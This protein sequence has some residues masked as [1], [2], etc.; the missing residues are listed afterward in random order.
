[1]P[2]GP[3][4]ASRPASGAIRAVSPC[5]DV[6][7]FH[8]SASLASVLT[9][10]SC[11]KD[12]P[13][14]FRFCGAC[15]SVLTDPI[16]REV[17]K[18]VTLLFT[19]VS[20]STA[21]GE[22]RDPEAIRSVMDRYF[23]VMREVIERH[24][25]TVEKFVGDA[26]MAVF[27]IPTVHED[28][29][30][31][32][33]RAATEMRERLAVLNEDLEREW[34]IHIAIRT[35]V[36]TGEVIAGDS[37]TRETFVTGD[38]VNTAARLEQSAGAGEILIGETTYRLVRHAVEVEPVDPLTLKG[39]VESVPAFRLLGLSQEQAMRPI[40]QQGILVARER[41]LAAI[42][43]SMREAIASRSCRLVTVIGSPGVGKSR[44][45]EESVRDPDFRVLRGGC[46]SYG[47]GITF[48][49]I[50]QMIRQAARISD[51]D[52][53]D[54]ARAR[55]RSLGLG[56]GERA[57]V[58]DRLFDL[59]GLGER[60]SGIEGTYLAVR[61]LVTWVA[62]AGPLAIVIEDV[63]WAEPGLL[64]LID[65]LVERTDGSIVVIVTARPEL[66]DRHPSWVED[67]P[68]RTVIALE[69]LDVDGSAD[70]IRSR[71]GE[72][73]VPLA[74]VV[75]GAAGGNPLFV[76]E[77]LSMLI[78]RGSLVRGPDGGWE[79]VGDVDELAAP[80]SIAAL[81]AARL[82]QLT[83]GDRSV[84]ERAAVVGVEFDRQQV[85][86]L[87]DDG[88]VTGLDGSLAQL[89]RRDLIRPRFALD[90]YEF[91][92]ALIRDEAY[93]SMPKLLRADL[94]ERFAT[95]LEVWARERAGAYDEIVG[96][97][98]ASAY[99]L[100]LELRPP[101]QRERG[102]ARRAGE[103]LALAGKRAWGRGDVASAAKLLDHASTLLPR[104]HSTR[105]ETLRLA[106]AALRDTGA[107]ERSLSVL[108]EAVEL[109]GE[110]GDPSAE[111]LAIC[112]RFDTR[113]VLGS[114]GLGPDARSLTERRIPQ[115]QTSGNHFGLAKAYRLLALIDWDELRFADSE[116]ACQM[117]VQHANL[118]ENEAE[119]A[120]IAAG[121]A[122]VD[123]Y[124]PRPVA[125]G[126]AR[127]EALLRELSGNVRAQAF[128]LGFLSGLEAMR[129]SFDRAH[130]K[131]RRSAR[132]I[133]EAGIGRWSSSIPL[134]L[135]FIQDLAGD[136][137]GAVE[138]LAP[139]VGSGSEDEIEI[140]ALYCRLLCQAGRSAET[141][142]IIERTGFAD[143]ANDVSIRVHGCLVTSH[144]CRGLGRTADAVRFAE[145]AVELLRDRDDAH[146]VPEAWVCLGL[147]QI[148]L[149][150]FESGSRHLGEAANLYERK[151]NLILLGRTRDLMG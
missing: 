77:L 91:R 63:H 75:V 124:G 55:I 74:T 78:D 37:S 57:A 33:V 94:H 150:R 24:G 85:E 32:A 110:L 31:R 12:N 135:A 54:E 95:W 47:D 147:A 40:R 22:D 128:I 18:R 2:S 14:G 82:D 20:G 113:R 112:E 51:E 39:K 148:E 64:Q 53:P 27:G 19:D 100:L 23:A 76:E 139:H 98:L 30:L 21:M 104:E 11:G 5:E 34:S 134:N 29:A 106:G 105:V 99:D 90:S 36:N 118:A 16:R 108:D 136:L 86:A 149:G 121:L 84:A 87:V 131:H 146:L 41:E 107:V 80:P 96:H 52:P 123:F 109:A 81:I 9:C 6:P 68:S 142:R 35:G 151:G 116:R 72:L 42:R 60:S 138:T 70:L 4:L 46:L 119:A 8:A 79:L 89:G 67:A 3:G 144:A 45:V 44:L 7:R 137:N 15:A 129:G 115:L 50:T 28:D 117:G 140:V 141:L 143:R 120:E 59:L 62:D 102:L 25:G 111:W 83:S 71:V 58:D 127:G 103:R 56:R 122:L 38:T 130:E 125:E 97:H 133:E 66:T 69:P 61:T 114:G 48:W 26:V 13:E 1:L 92:H 145:E 93:A 17:R 132:M 65:H 43:A 88:S 10:P 73:P 126:L 101:G 49:P